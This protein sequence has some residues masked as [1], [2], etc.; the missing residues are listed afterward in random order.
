MSPTQIG[1][2]T[3][4]G[5]EVAPVDDLAGS[6]QCMTQESGAPRRLPNVRYVPVAESAFVLPFTVEPRPLDVRVE[7]HFGSHR[8]ISPVYLTFLK[9]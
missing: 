7:D 3:L 8:S 2:L 4:E 1:R 6:G 5:A 9:D